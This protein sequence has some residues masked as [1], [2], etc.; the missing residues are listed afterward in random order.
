MGFIISGGGGGG[1]DSNTS[2]DGW[3]WSRPTAIWYAKLG[4]IC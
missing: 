1:A 4:S 2:A 3:G